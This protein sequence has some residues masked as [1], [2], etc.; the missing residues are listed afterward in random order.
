MCPTRN[1]LLSSF[2]TSLKILKYMGLY[3]VPTIESATLVSLIK[4]VLLR[5]N[6]AINRLRGQCYDGASAMKGAKGG[7][8]KKICDLESR[9]VYTHCYGHSLNLAA[10]DILKDSK[11]M[12]EALETTHEITKLIKYSPRRDGIFQK[13]KEDIPSGPTPGI[14]ILCPTRWTVKADSLASIITNFEVLQS[15]WVEAASVTKDTETKARIH[16][17]SAVMKTIDF[18]YGA[19]LGEL[20]LKH[21]DN[22]SRTLQNKSMSAAEGQQIALMTIETLKRIRNDSSFDLFWLKVNKFVS[23]HDIAGAD[24]PRRRKRPARYDDGLSSGDYHDTQKGYYRQHYFEALDLTINC[25]LNRFD[26]PG[27]K[28]YSTLETLLTKSCKGEEIDELLEEVCDFYK[29]DFEKEVLRT[30]LEIFKV[31]FQEEQ[32]VNAVTIF[33]LKK[34]FSSLSGGQA[35][36]ICQVT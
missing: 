9:A 28:I 11:I 1:K 17:V 23:A 20:L 34:Y 5:M 36:L 8:A 22:L 33:D 29:D 4:D 32:E 7:V 25:I 27:Y 13:I 2:V 6:L 10:S 15:T 16:G 12:K 26:Q 31:H 19:I 35:S 18:I 21:A 3:H 14:R 24:L 30:Q